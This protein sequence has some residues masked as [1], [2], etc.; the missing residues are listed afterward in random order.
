[1]KKRL[2]PVYPLLTLVLAMGLVVV[3]AVSFAGGVALA[4]RTGS[5]V[6]AD[7]SPSV[8]VVSQPLVLESSW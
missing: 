5:E 6:K 2:T 1:M 4:T 3:I 7:Q 8:E